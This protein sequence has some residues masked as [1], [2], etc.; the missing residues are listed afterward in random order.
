MLQKEE[1]ETCLPEFDVEI[2]YDDDEVFH[3]T[4]IIYSLPPFGCEG[5]VY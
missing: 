4:N 5:T 3:S 2:F 1:L